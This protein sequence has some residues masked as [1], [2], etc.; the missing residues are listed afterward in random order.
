M[1][2]GAI[3]A[4]VAISNRNTFF[5]SPSRETYDLVN[6]ENVAADSLI[7]SG[8]SVAAI[9]FVLDRFVWPVQHTHGTVEVAR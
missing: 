9:T 8:L 1:I 5:S 4:A 3:V 7:I 6:T 2:A